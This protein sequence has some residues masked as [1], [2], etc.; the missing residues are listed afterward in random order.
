MKRERERERG[1]P[2]ALVHLPV[3]STMIKGRARRPCHGGAQAQPAWARAAHTCGAWGPAAAGPPPGHHAV[4]F[5]FCSDPLFFLRVVIYL[6]FL[7]GDGRRLLLLHSFPACLLPLIEHL[8]YRATAILPVSW[9]CVKCRGSVADWLSE[10]LLFMSS[11][12]PL[13]CFRPHS[14]A[15]LVRMCLCICMCLGW[16]LRYD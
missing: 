8:P 2:P 9:G 15:G 5:L 4:L 16:P 10:V 11:L 12:F 13:P 7:C 6:F 1:R 14:S 3:V